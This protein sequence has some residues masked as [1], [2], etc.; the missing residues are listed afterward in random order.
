MSGLKI[1]WLGRVS[2]AAA[3]EMQHAFVELKA[4]DTNAADHLFLLEHDPIYTTGRGTE[5]EA[6]GVLP[7]QVL[8]T[9]RGGKVTFHGPG[10]L[11]GYPVL[12]LRRRGQDLHRYLR[13]LEEG[14]IRLSAM[15]GVQA[16]AREGLT[17]VWVG[18]RKLASLGVG[19][20]RW[21]TMHGFA[22]NVCGPLDG[23]DHI[24]PCGLEGVEMTSLEREGANGCSVEAV[25]AL[26]QEAFAD[27]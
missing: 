8:Q 2:Y 15:F 3:L 9:N 23:F 12:D 14:L 24:T 4:E 11:V 18:P 21:I 27:I 1:Q 19:V 17:G 22:L 13:N 26:A 10:Q 16:T 5:V 6:L 25:A 20:R 7:H